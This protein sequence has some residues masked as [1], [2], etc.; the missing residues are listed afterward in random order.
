MARITGIH[1]SASREF[2]NAAFSSRPGANRATRVALISMVIPR[3]G[4][5]TRRALRSWDIFV[6][7]TLRACEFFATE[8]A[9]VVYGLCT[10]LISA[11]S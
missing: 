3:R 8:L 6:A 4:S 5:R 10:N 9:S 1:R 7:V 2:A 11:G